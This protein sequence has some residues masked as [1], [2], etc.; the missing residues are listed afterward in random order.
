ES[1]MDRKPTAVDEALRE[2]YVVTPA[3]AE[4][5]LDYE[6]QESAMRLY[7]PELIQGIDLR[8]EAKRLDH[9]DFASTRTPKRVRT[10]TREVKGPELTGAE[11]SLDEAEKVYAARDLPRARNMFLDVLKQS[12]EKPIHAKAYYGLARVAVLDKDPETGDRLF[13]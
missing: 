6:K 13:R 11:K 4:G 9:V 10:V 12:Q 3:L 1:R 8:K 2:G 5:L 7:F